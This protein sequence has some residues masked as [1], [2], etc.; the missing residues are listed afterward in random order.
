MAACCV[1]TPTPLHRDI[2]E[3]LDIMLRRGIMEHRGIT[4]HRGIAGITILTA[5]DRLFFELFRIRGLAKRAPGCEFFY[6]DDDIT[7]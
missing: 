4:E 5:G 3:H 1:T 7:E 6:R 2:T